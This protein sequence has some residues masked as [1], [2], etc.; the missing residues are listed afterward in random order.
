[1][2][3][4]YLTVQD[5]NHNKNIICLKRNKESIAENVSQIGAAFDARR[6]RVENMQTMLTLFG[7]RAPWR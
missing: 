4:N 7:L 5:N 2:Q 3:D 6:E 1:M